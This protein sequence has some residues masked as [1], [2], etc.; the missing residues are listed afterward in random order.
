MGAMDVTLQDRF[1]ENVNHLLAEKE[2]S[3]SDLA[4]IMG[5]TPQYVSN[6]L[7]G[8]KSPGLDVIARFAEAL[9]VDP[10][11]LLAEPVTA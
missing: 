11:L 3:R 4:R 6:Y 5:A 10:G 8:V 1:H 9:D 2:L 7:N